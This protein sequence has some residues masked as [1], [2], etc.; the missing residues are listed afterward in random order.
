MRLRP[1]DPASR[2][3]SM[4][5]TAASARKRP[6]S[7]A[8]CGTL[9]EPSSLRSRR[10]VRPAPALCSDAGAPPSRG[11]ALHMHMLH[12]TAHCIYVSTGG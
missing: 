9:M 8:R 10:R 4:A 6:S 5:G 3:N 12:P 1:V 7:S 11:A 2:L